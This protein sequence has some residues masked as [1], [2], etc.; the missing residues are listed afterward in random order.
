MSEVFVTVMIGK[1]LMDK[2]KNW[3][4]RMGVVPMRGGECCYGCA[5][6]DKRVLYG[7]SVT[8]CYAAR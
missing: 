5:V 7:I 8:I 4:V 2:C 1:V 3:M 6:K